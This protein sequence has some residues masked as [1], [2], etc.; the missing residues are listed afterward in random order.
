MVPAPA[1][2]NVEQ[3]T[4]LQGLQDPRKG[5][6]WDILEPDIISVKE[7]NKYV[8]EIPSKQ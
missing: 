4:W 3:S 1:K 5:T 7:K 8:T 6:V 2:A